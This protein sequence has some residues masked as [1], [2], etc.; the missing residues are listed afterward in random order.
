[1]TNR[2]MGPPVKLRAASSE[3]LKCPR[4]ESSWFPISMGK[5]TSRSELP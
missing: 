4:T 1:M 2:V 5:R 3:V